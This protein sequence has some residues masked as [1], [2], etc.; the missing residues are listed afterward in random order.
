MDHVQVR[1]GEVVLGRG[2]RAGLNAGVLC[3]VVGLGSPRRRLLPLGQVQVCV[4]DV[5]VVLDLNVAERR[6]FW[7]PRATCP[8]IG[9]KAGCF[10]LPLGPTGSALIH[11]P[12]FSGPGYL[13]PAL[14]FQSPHSLKQLPALSQP[15]PFTALPQCPSS[16][17]SVLPFQRSS[18]HLL[19]IPSL[20]MK[21]TPSCTF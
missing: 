11:A 12:L 14:P 8:P 17:S 4:G 10:C 19:S 13:P 16:Q 15:G 5:I 20:V 1:V 21:P 18:L 2:W 7:K 3:V 6:S 9:T